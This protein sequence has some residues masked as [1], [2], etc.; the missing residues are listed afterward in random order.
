M[1]TKSVISSHRSRLS[2]RSHVTYS[3]EKFFLLNFVQWE[4]TDPT[5]KDF[6]G[7]LLGYFP[8]TSINQGQHQGGLRLTIGRWSEL[9]SSGLK[10]EKLFW[11]F[12]PQ[13]C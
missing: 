7:G 6:I 3:L 11:V 10:L 9:R 12:R 4:L 13:P 5:W 1:P 8:E 2:P